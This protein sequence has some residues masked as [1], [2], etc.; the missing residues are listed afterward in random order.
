M[1]IYATFIN[2]FP[3]LDFLITLA[4]SELFPLLQTQKQRLP[5][6]FKWQKIDRRTKND[7]S[8]SK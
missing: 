5:G 1:K 4:H 3:L 7:P 6:T 8:E 2:L